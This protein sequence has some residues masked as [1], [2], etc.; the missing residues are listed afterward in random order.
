MSNIL[1]V[2]PDYRYFLTLIHIHRTEELF[3]QWLCRVSVDY[4]QEV[5][6]T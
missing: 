6:L 1:E 5:T 3:R 4:V 2:L